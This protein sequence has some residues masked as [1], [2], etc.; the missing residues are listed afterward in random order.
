MTLLNRMKKTAVRF[1]G[2]SL[3][4]LANT[5]L[6][7]LLIFV[8]NRICGV[9]YL[10]SYAAAY[11]LTVLL[12]YAANALWV[13]HVGLALADCIRFVM[14]YISGMLL[15]MGLLRLGR[16]VFPCLDETLLSYCVI[17][18]TTVGNF[19]FVNKVLSGKKKEVSHA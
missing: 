4:G 15:G 19:W 5:F 9:H 12:A 13:F 11:V 3:I 2:F 8:L 14:T 6:S 1:S 16:Y 17:P 7:M 10:I 18:V